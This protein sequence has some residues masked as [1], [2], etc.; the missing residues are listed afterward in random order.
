MKVFDHFPKFVF[1][2]FLKK[3][4]KQFASTDSV[5]ETTK[6]ETAEKFG[7]QYWT[8]YD[9]TSAISY[10]LQALIDLSRHNYSGQKLKIRLAVSYLYILV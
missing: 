1:G 7:A 9:T 2:L 10:I 5:N 3:K 8:F 6:C 4:K